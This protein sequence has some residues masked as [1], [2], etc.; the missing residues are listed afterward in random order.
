MP[1]SFSV[2]GDPDY[3][4]LLGRL[5]DI[6]IVHRNLC[7][8]PK[9]TE[10]TLSAESITQISGT[11]SLSLD[12]PIPLRSRNV[13][14]KSERLVLKRISHACISCIVTEKCAATFATEAEKCIFFVIR[15]KFGHIECTI[16]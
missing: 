11:T 1:V 4:F 13:R 15:T 2:F 3:Q 10:V 8:S 6:R 14:G 16:S 5:T 9:S 12:K 7:C